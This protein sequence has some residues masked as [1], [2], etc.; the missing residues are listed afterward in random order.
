[1]RF[2]QKFPAIRRGMHAPDERLY[3]VNELRQCANCG[4]LTDWTDVA[5]ELSVCSEECQY[6]L[7]TGKK[8]RGIGELLVKE[9]LITDAQLEAALETQRRLPTYAPLGQILLDMRLLTRKQLHTVLDKHGKRPQ[10]GRVLI[11]ARAI[12][13]DQLKTALVHQRRMS[14]RLGDALL[15]LGFV[16]DAAL[17]QAICV[18]LNIAF[19]DLQQVAA[20][21]ALAKLIKKSY[22]ER[23]RVLPVAR[24]GGSLTVAMDDPTDT[25]VLSTLE[26]STGCTINVVTATRAAFDQALARL[27]SP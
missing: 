16:T 5:L 12:T 19:L 11:A 26:A 15:K 25:E 14:L 3:R 2:T 4:V 18:Q 10:L 13:E 17:K 8:P 9:R 24:I 22:A 20:D 6:Q 1:M 27:Y 23:H 7:S 21:P